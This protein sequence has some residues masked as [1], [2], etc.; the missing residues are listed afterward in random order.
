MTRGLELEEVPWGD[1]GEGVQ[2]GCEL[3]L[4]G[5]EIR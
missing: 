5:T 1:G 4:A 3:K 2:G